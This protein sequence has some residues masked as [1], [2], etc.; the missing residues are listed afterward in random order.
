MPETTITSPPTQ[1]HEEAQRST[2]NICGR[3][4]RRLVSLEDVHADLKSIIEANAPAV[5]QIAHACP[6]C[7]ELFTR[8]KAQIDSHAAIFEQASFVLPTPLR[9]NADERFTGRGVTMAFLDSGFYK[10]PDLV[11]P[12]N[13]IVAYHSIFVTDGDP[14]SLETT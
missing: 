14:T 6:N 9:M 5:E 10:H 12:K 2:C 8:A 13:R 1:H 4:R 11:E 3:E 7:V